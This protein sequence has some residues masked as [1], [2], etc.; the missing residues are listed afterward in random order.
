MRKALPVQAQKGGVVTMTINTVDTGERK[1]MFG[2]HRASLEANH[3]DGVGPGR[4][5]AKQNEIENDGWYINLEYGLAC[6]PLAGHRRWA[7]HLRVVAI[8][9]SITGLAR[10][11]SVFTDRDDHDVRRRWPPHLYNDDG[12]G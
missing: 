11:R 4:L 10:R 2:F 6:D 7:Q 9:I 1:E 5:L 12:S 8:V 3:D